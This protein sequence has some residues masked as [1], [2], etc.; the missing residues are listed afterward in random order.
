MIAGWDPELLDRAAA[1][2]VSSAGSACKPDD[3]GGGKEG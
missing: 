1:G 2:T 3:E